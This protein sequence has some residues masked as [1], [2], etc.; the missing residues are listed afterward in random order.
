[1]FSPNT[2]DMSH[3]SLLVTD[4]GP[5][6]CGVGFS[7]VTS[8]PLT[9]SVP[10]SGSAVQYSLLNR[11]PSMASTVT[12]IPRFWPSSCAM[13]SAVSCEVSCPALW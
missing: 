8:S 4:C 12:L 6:F 2:I 10:P 11:V 7:Q 9:V 13:N 5:G 3:G 1:M